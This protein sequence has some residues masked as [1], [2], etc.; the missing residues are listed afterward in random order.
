MSK[1]ILA[2]CFAVIWIVCSATSLR[3]QSE[4]GGA[5]V[6]GTVTDATGAAIP[7]AKVTARSP[8]TGFVRTIASRETG[9]YTFSGMPTGTYD[10]AVEATGF[11][12]AVQKD[13]VLNVGAVVTV[14]VRMEVGSATET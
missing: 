3:A 6:N 14:D 5:T 1:H 10:I 4:V 9:L 13:V 8:Q 2:L 7:N 11:K 12:T